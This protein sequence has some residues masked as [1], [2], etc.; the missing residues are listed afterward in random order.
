MAS[1]STLHGGARLT[2]DLQEKLKRK[3]FW[4]RQKVM[5]MAVRAG[6]GHISSAFSQTEMLVAL[7]QGGILRCRP[8]E[9]RWSDRDRMVPSR[10]QGGIGFYPILADMGYFPLAELDNFC[11]EG[12]RLGVH[13][14]WEVPGVEIISGSLGHGLPIATGMAQ[15]ALN[16]GK[17]YLVYCYLG[18][19][20]LYEGSNWEAAFFAGKKRQHNLIC[21]VDRNGQGVLGF[22]EGD[23]TS[24]DGPGIE[25]LDK[26]FEAFNFEVRVIDGHDYGQ[27]YAALADV[28]T[29]KSDQPLAIIAK[30]LKGKGLSL[31][32][33]QRMWHYRVPAADE[34]QQALREL[35]LDPAAVAA[36]AGGKTA[37]G[38]QGE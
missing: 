29:R 13:M 38:E 15:V 34:L 1:V 14:E 6:S 25:P 2:A 22:T 28:R 9:P 20:E 7:Y 26:K 24:R 17:D 30:T 32:E 36:P 23:G 19:G 16:E 18:D 27:I 35:Q 33:N 3:A 21:I 31:M 8:Q 5:E 4:V 11:G 10:G 37:E 12:S